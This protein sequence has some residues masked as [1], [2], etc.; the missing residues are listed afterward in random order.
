MQECHCD[1]R[2]VEL[3]MDDKCTHFYISKLPHSRA[4]FKQ[5]VREMGTKGGKRDSERRYE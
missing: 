1:I 4:G 5:L 2:P 3:G